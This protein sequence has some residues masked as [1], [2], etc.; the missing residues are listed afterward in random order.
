MHELRSVSGVAVAGVLARRISVVALCA[1]AAA[2]CRHARDEFFWV[3]DIP[4]A[5]QSDG[6]YRIARGDVVG[7]RVWQQEAMSI[8]RLRVRDDGKISIP[9]LQDVEV[10]GMTPAELAG[11][12]QAKLKTY[13]VNPVVTV[14]LVEQPLMRVSVVGEVT[15]PGAY[16]LDRAAG[17]LHAVAAAGGLTEYAH[18]DRIFVL[19]YGYWADGNPAPARIR[20]RWDTL[21][22]GGAKA[23]TF[24]LRTGDVVVVE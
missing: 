16:E 1:I 18:R 10:D 21:S 14:T 15:H 4:T 20:F 23:A 3:D 11:R 12:I 8:E 17:V 9:F 24:R 7:V 6:E 5:R 2:G 13:I 22:R 19:R